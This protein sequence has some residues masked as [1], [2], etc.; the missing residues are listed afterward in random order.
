MAWPPSTD[1]LLDLVAADVYQRVDTYRFD[2]TDHGGDVIGQLTPDFE[3]APRMTNDTGRSVMRTIDN[4]QL[5]ASETRHID[6]IKDRCVVHMVLENGAEE[7]LGEFLWGDDTHPVREWGHEHHS[8]LVDLLHPLTSK[9]GRTSGSK[10]GQ[11]VVQR[12]VDHARLVVSAVVID[13]VPDPTTLVTPLGWTPD[14]TYQA[15]IN[16]H[17]KT[18]GYLPCYYD[19]HSRLQIRPVPDPAVSQATLFYGDAGRIERD[20]ITESDDNLK[21][22]NEFVA[23]DSSAQGTPRIGRYRIPAD[24]PHSVE[25]RS[26]VWRHVEGIQGLASQA[27]ADKAARA[28]A[29]LDRESTYAWRTWTSAAD[30]R[31]DTFDIIDFYGENYLEVRWTLELAPGGRMTHQARRVY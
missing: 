31:H 14:D 13:A 22:P 16:D 19:R 5:P 15:I 9:S 27:A 18:V 8:V 7:R 23:Y 12:A 29:T 30:P 2:L 11:N 21:A 28:M 24:A 26:Y 3:S 10:V 1:D 4:L 20:S 6:G 25:N 17:L